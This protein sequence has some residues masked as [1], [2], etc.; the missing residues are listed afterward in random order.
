MSLVG[1]IF[2]RVR[3]MVG[4]AECPMY[5][6]CPDYDLECSICTRTRGRD[7]DGIRAPCYIAL[8]KTRT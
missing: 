5:Q 1:K 3:I 4:D 6:K 7:E 8:K 2:D